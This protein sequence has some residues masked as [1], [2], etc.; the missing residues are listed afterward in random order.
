VAQYSA[1]D[2][3]NLHLRAYAALITAALAGC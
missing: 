3:D 1:E 2:P